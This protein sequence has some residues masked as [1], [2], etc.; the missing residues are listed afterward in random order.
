MGMPIYKRM[1]NIWG[2]P[3]DLGNHHMALDLKML[4]SYSQW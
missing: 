1:K 2:Y 4:G 3:Y